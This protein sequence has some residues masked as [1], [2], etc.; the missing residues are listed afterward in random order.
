MTGALILSGAPTLGLHAATKQYADDIAANAAPLQQLLAAFVCTADLDASVTT[1]LGVPSLTANNTDTYCSSTDGQSAT[2]AG[3]YI[4]VAGQTDPA[5][6]GLYVSY[7][8]A[9]PAS[10]LPFIIQRAPD[11]L[12]PA[13]YRS[14]LMVS[15]SSG[16]LYAKSQWVHATAQ[17]TVLGTDALIF[18]SHFGQSTAQ[19]LANK[20]LG[21]TTLVST[22]STLGDD[23]ALNAGGQ[24][25]TLDADDIELLCAAGAATYA[26]APVGPNDLVNKAYADALALG[27]IPQAGVRC[28]SLTDVAATYANG[29]SGVGATLTKTATNTDFVQDDITLLLNE[30]MLVTAQTLVEENGVYYLSTAAAVG[31]AA[32][33]TRST[34]Y[35]VQAELQRGSLFYAAEGTLGA[36]KLYAQTSASS[37]VVGTDEVAYSQIASPLSYTAGLNMDITGSVIAGITNP[38]V[39]NLRLGSGVGNFIGI[40]KGAGGFS[41]TMEMP[42]APPTADQILSYNGTT[43]AFDWVDLPVG[44]GGGGTP[45]VY[46]ASY[47]GGD[48]TPTGAL[49]IS[50]PTTAFVLG[51]NITHPTS[52]TFLLQPGFTYRLVGGVN[53]ASMG[54]TLSN[55]NWANVGTGGSF[56]SYGELTSA[57]YTGAL[58]YQGHA[59][60]YITPIVA[61]TVALQSGGAYAVRVA[62][63][64]IESVSSGGGGGG[65]TYT[66]GANIDLSGDVVAVIAAPD[67]ATSM[68]TPSAKV[69]VSGN[70]V[71]LTKYAGGATY[72]LALPPAAP[73]AT[74]YLASDGSGNLS[75]TDPSPAPIAPPTD[76]ISYLSAIT[77]GTVT[78]NSGDYSA[79]PFATSHGQ[80]GTLVT[81]P[82]SSTFAIKGGAVV[83][84]CSTVWKSSIDNGVSREYVWWSDNLAGEISPHGSSIVGGIDTRDGTIQ[85]TYAPIADDIIWLTPLTEVSGNNWSFQAGVTIFTLSGAS[86]AFSSNTFNVYDHTTPTKI[87][88]FD[89]SALPVGTTTLALPAAGFGTP[90][91]STDAAF[92]VSNAATPSKKVALNCGSITTATTRT[93]TVPDADGTI[94]ISS[95]ATFNDD[96][97]FVVD[98]VAPTKRATFD[99]GGITAGTTRTIFLPNQTGAMLLNN[100]CEMV[101]ANCIIGAISAGTKRMKFDCSG[102]TAATT[103]TYV[104]PDSDGTLA[105]QAY[106]NS[107]I[108]AAL[109][110]AS[111]LLKPYI[112]VVH[113][114]TA[115]GGSIAASGSWQRRPLNSSIRLSNVPGTSLSGNQLVAV[116]AGEYNVAASA[117]FEKTNSTMIRLY[118]TTNAVVLKRGGYSNTGAGSGQITNPINLFGRVTLT[119]TATIELQYWC[120][121]DAAGT[122]DMGRYTATDGSAVV[123]ARLVMQGMS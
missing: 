42:P 117:I 101:D 97:L 98:G 73:A 106:V 121:T 27:L 59:T 7:Q 53:A 50:L 94:A 45:E 16:T 47:S 32:I 112:E 104:A 37:P 6:N 74:Q 123:Y 116:P 96:G 30:R 43:S 79:I 20:E 54:T 75:W 105:L 71:A 57:A 22:L 110:A 40:S 86:V 10:G 90:G 49:Y 62:Y 56:G 84:I 4:L 72:P 35:D 92:W 5:E 26:K 44:G 89:A 76:P 85:T 48:V 109:A 12:T 14:G 114:D 70:H 120:E 80:Y 39:T 103:R 55:V 68:T 28:V 61:T 102:I 2:I 9:G 23:M 119:T 77:T 17:P 66:S 64:N 58:C 18:V 19:T 87:A 60:A 31:V 21:P 107:Q 118:D 63:A 15:V 13:S 91:Q 82:T 34:D 52:T 81:Q 108:A 33:L 93:L 51:T 8:V 88:K 69:G 3:T 78:R 24:K 29:A 25:I 83:F 41:Y 100:S 122:V 67:F 95:A 38:L 111:P 65:T 115:D 36:G 11:F 46:H 99:A 1:T 113:A